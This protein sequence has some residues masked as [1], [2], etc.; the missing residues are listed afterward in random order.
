MVSAKGPWQHHAA[1]WLSLDA[2]KKLIERYRI[3]RHELETAWEAFPPEIKNLLR[4]PPG[5]S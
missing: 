1:A 3:E 2:T 5:M 4:P